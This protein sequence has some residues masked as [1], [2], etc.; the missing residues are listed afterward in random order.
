MTKDQ[1]ELDAR[2]NRSSPKCA[3]CHSSK[4]PPAGSTAVDE[5]SVV[6]AAVHETGFSRGQFPIRRKALS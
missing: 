2:A 4:R 5:E 3:K 1:T 6:P